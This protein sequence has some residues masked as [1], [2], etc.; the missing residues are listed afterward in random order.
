MGSLLLSRSYSS[1]MMPR[2]GFLSKSA[3]HFLMR[4][5]TFFL[6]LSLVVCRRES[7]PISVSGSR[8]RGKEVQAHAIRHHALETLGEGFGGDLLV[9]IG[10]TVL[11][12]GVSELQGSTQSQF[13]S[14]PRDGRAEARGGT[15]LES[16]ELDV[17]VP[18]GKSLL[19]S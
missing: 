10:A 17:G 9:D 16:K 1:P 11:G 3:T 14:S 4:A 8:A 15:D 19:K 5:R 13:S 6:T 2:S 18:V 12:E 7:G